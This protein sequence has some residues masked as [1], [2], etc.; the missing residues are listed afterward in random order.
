MEPRKILQLLADG[1]FHS[2]TELAGHLHVSRAAVWKQIEQLRELQVAVNSVR[3]RGYRLPGGMVLIDA[4][5]VRAAMPAPARELLAELDIRDMVDST[6][7]VA[8]SRVRAGAA[9]GYCC[10]A[11]FQSSGRGRRGRNWVSPYGAGICM[12]V[13]WEFLGG[14]AA[15]EGLSLAVGVAVAEALEDAGVPVRLKWPNDLLLADAKLGGILIELGGDAGGTCQA[16]IGIGINVALPEDAAGSIDQA[17]ADLRNA[18]TRDRNLLAGKVLGRLLPALATFA[19]SG[20]AP[21]R[22][23][24]SARDALRGRLVEVRAGAEPWSGIADGID[25]QGGLRV[26]APG[27]EQVVRG[28]EVT[29]RPREV[30]DAA[31]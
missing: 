23:R 7:S 8:Q 16:I 22:E 17:W 11:E 25:R 13:V 27:G 3:G 19:G 31:G 20:L 29:V 26:L 2:G 14:V 10:L 18:A 30:P 24:W 12:T 5:L 6:N 1:R 15:L 4:D 9:H 28:G 21:F